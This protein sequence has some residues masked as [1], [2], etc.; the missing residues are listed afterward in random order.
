MKIKWL[1]FEAGDGVGKSTQVQ[2]L[3]DYYKT[4]RNIEPFVCRQPGNTELGN[5]IRTILLGDKYKDCMCKEA[6]RLLF[7]ADHAQFI[8]E[9]IIPM[10]DSNSIIIQDRYTAYSN[11]VYGVCGSGVDEGFMELLNIATRG[12]YPDVVFLLDLDPE[13]A[14][15]RMDLRGE[16]KTRVD[17]LDIE[18]HRRVRAGYLKLAKTDMQKFKIID[19]SKNPQ[20][21]HQEIIESLLKMER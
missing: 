4:E 3:A 7:A 15:E 5:I 11:F 6:E 10:M 20:L 9:I 13:V 14:R 17:K 8:E 12:Y 16:M 2:M 1:V 18:F 21:I 19:A